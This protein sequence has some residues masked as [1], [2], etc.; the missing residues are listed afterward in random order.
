MLHATCAPVG[1]IGVHLLPSMPD[2]GGMQG[3]WQCLVHSTARTPR[4]SSRT[5]ECSSVGKGCS[6]P[7]QC[8]DCDDTEQPCERGENAASGCRGLLHV[9]SFQELPDD[10][11]N[12]HQVKSLD[13]VFRSISFAALRSCSQSASQLLLYPSLAPPSRRCRQCPEYF[14]SSSCSQH[15]ASALACR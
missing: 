9:G 15:T 1:V 2:R 13:Q 14:P 5:R 7:R 11:Q 12:P 10:R 8:R 6:W 3:V 4:W